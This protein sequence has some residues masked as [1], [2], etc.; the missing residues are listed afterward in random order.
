MKEEKKT[1][2]EWQIK[3]QIQQ[4]KINTIVI[5]P[6]R[7]LC[8]SQLN[9]KCER[10]RNDNSS[11]IFMRERFYCLYAVEMKFFCILNELNK[12]KQNEINKRTNERMNEQ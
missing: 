2:R 6:M 9:R 4:F 3:F 5:I 1:E 11:N 8:D 7:V 10:E 12:T